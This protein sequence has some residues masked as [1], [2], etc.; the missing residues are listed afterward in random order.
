MSSSSAHLDLLKEITAEDRTRI[1]KEA[2]SLL[3]FFDL[4][5]SWFNTT[6]VYSYLRKYPE[7][8]LSDKYKCVDALFEEHD[9]TMPVLE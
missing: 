4:P 8:S 3:T 7:A 5:L 1:V 9:S 6:Y 2:N